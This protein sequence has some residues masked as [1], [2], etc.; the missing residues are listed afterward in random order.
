M[1]HN[2]RDW[3]R[4][5]MMFGELSMNPSNFVRIPAQAR[6]YIPL[7]SGHPCQARHEP[8]ILALCPAKALPGPILAQRWDAGLNSITLL[9]TPLIFVSISLY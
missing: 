8:S 1:F 4:Q 9:L 2:S 3:H 7:A 5:R 6:Q